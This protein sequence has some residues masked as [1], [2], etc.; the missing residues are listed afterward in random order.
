MAIR[1]TVTYETK[2]GSVFEHAFE[3]MTAVK[4]WQDSFGFD[5]LVRKGIIAAYELQV[6]DGA[7]KRTVVQVENREAHSKS[8]RA[9]NVG[10]SGVVE[11]ASAGVEARKE[12]RGRSSGRA[13]VGRDCKTEADAAWYRLGAGYGGAVRIGYRILRRA[14][15]FFGVSGLPGRRWGKPGLA[16]AGSGG[17]RQGEGEHG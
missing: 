10:G 1:Y 3:S 14:C 4:E 12:K 5:S 9:F 8:G 15:R 17:R 16:V 11:S 13:Y 2:G 7:T 6:N